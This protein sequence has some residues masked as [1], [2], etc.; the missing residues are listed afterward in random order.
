[1]KKNIMLVSLLAVLLPV[2]CGAVPPEALP[3]MH[4][5]DDT[6]L[7]QR[8]QKIID[9]IMDQNLSQ[10]ARR[11]RITQS[12]LE[13]L[14]NP[15]SLDAQNLRA[16]VRRMV[17][18]G[19]DVNGRDENGNKVLDAALLTG[20]ADVVKFL[21]RKDASF[22]NGACNEGSYLLALAEKRV[23]VKGR[24]SKATGKAFKSD[25]E[26]AK[27]FRSRQVLP[28]AAAL[29]AAVSHQNE[30]LAQ[31]YIS[32]FGVNRA[33][34]NGMTA[35]H[36]LAQRNDGRGVEYLLKAGADAALKNKKG[37]TAADLATLPQVKA[38]FAQAALPQ[39]TS[40][41][42]KERDGAAASE[43]Q[44]AAASAE[45]PSAANQEQAPLTQDPYPL[46]RAARRGDL[47]RAQALIQN[48]A[49]VNSIL[50]QAD[51]RT[52][53]MEAARFGHEK[54]TL[55]LIEKGADLNKQSEQGYTALIWSVLQGKRS[56]ARLLAQKGA[57]LNLTDRQGNTALHY[58]IQYNYEALS[59]YLKKKGARTDIKN[60]AGKT[61][62]Q[63]EKEKAEA[64]ASPRYFSK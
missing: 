33:Q 3:T 39:E 58:A 14:E 30:A 10:A 22:I 9:V 54:V 5:G 19:A 7:K 8:E 1:M 2:I 56:A 40:A 61:A 17:G 53:L 36:L 21:V 50:D 37:D 12:L 35:L 11:E 43:K 24:P 41:A 62:A 63:M 23:C 4:F 59:S 42:Q 31:Y 18:A 64:Y 47:T 25:V 29:A 34:G 28:D 26:L 44:Q 46:H 6:T 48:G 51:L 27:F 16:Q 45:Q 38:L 57:D 20:N 32:W 13:L 49:D 55:L 15:A 52:P 60:K